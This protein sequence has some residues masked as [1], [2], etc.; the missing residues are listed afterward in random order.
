MRRT[1]ALAAA[2][3]GTLGPL[4]AAAWLVASFRGERCFA[5]GWLSKATPAFGKPCR[6]SVVRALE[7]TQRAGDPKTAPEIMRCAL[8]L[9]LIAAARAFAP[10]S[11][12]RA[13]VVVKNEADAA[14]TA[15]ES[16]GR[17]SIARRVVMPRAL[18]RASKLS[19]RTQT[20]RRR[21]SIAC[22]A[23]LRHP[24]PTEIG[25]GRNVPSLTRPAHT[26]IG[27]THQPRS[28]LST[29]T[30]DTAPHG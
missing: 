12:L 18:R 5:G 21:H 1:R 19:L 17:I 27:H 2:A 13:S 11:I 8:L 3:T 22:N 28:R 14:S 9:S 4:C 24:V 16:H 29:R 7:R 20:P 15:P 6:A 26:H 10:P 25:F 23:C 30:A